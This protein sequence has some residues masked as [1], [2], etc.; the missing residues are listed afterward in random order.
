MGLKK[1]ANW[2]KE[3]K[4]EILIGAGCFICGGALCGAAVNFDQIKALIN[5]KRLYAVTSCYDTKESAD[6]FKNYLR[7]F[8]GLINGSYFGYNLSEEAA[9]EAV[10]KFVS[11]QPDCLYGIMIDRKVKT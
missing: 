6:A 9:Q 7:N 4:K 5:G 10:S 8:S 11:E 3:H 2:A 1:V